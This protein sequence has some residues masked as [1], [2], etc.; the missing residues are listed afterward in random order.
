LSDLIIGITILS[1][2]SDLGSNGERSS[3]GLPKESFGVIFD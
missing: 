1:S 3:I 2:N